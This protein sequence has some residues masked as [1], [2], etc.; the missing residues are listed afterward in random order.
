MSVI[1]RQVSTSGTEEAAAAEDATDIV[2][3]Y[4]FVKC[5]ELFDFAV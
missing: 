1:I 4:E 5:C 3:F 2:K